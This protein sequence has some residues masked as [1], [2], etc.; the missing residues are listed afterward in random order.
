MFYKCTLNVMGVELD[1]T[2]MLVN[3]DDV[4]LSLKRSDYDGVIRSY[5]TKFEFAGE[6]RDALWNEYVSNYTG[7]SAEIVFSKR[8]N[9]WTYDEVFRCALDFSSLTDDGLK[10]SINA[11]DN[12]LAALIKSKKGTQYEYAVSE[13][14]EDSQLRYDR[15]MLTNTCKW[16]DGSTL[17]EDG[18]YSV[19]T[20]LE[21]IGFMAFPLFISGDPEI[22]VKDRCEVYDSGWDTGFVTEDKIATLQPF[23]KAI[24]PIDLVLSGKFKAYTTQW[25]TSGVVRRNHIQL[26]IVK[27]D[28]TLSVRRNI[29]IYNQDYAETWVNFYNESISLDAGDALLLVYKGSYA[30]AGNYEE[31][32]IKNSTGISVE[33]ISRPDPVMIDMIEPVT[34]LNRLLK[35]MNGGNEGYTGEIATAVDERLDMAR[36]IAAESARGLTNA[37]LYTSYTKFCNWMSA[38]FGFVPVVGD[39]TVKFVHRSSL[40]TDTKVKELESVTDYEYSVKPSLIYS[41]IRVGYDKKDYDSVNGKD[42]FNF[43]TEYTTGVTLTDNKLELISPYRADAYG[44]EFLVQKRGEDTTGDNSDNDVFF[45]G[46]EWDIA[47]GA[48][49]PLR[50][51]EKYSTIIGGMMTY[52]ARFGIEGVLTPDTMFNV[53][54]AAKFMIEANKGYIGVCCDK[55]EYASADGNSDYTI[56]DV[57]PKTDIEL[58]ERLFTVGELKVTTGDNVIPSMTEGYVTVTRNGQEFKGYIQ[59]VDFNLGRAESVG[60]TLIV[61]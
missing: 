2:D 14:K 41:Y 7:A 43:T 17:S 20:P 40:F 25:A 19:I 31:I 56:N 38:V 29:E 49:I 59:D 45:V 5:S 32:F 47:K 26:Y 53:M 36:I 60:Y 37:K 52:Y 51:T 44:L 4:E 21:G 27:E 58:G 3:W 50:K 22:A 8:N 34:V 54:Y 18:T 1:A 35:S 30:V 42:E 24:E 23:F 61:K 33:F 6:I 48:Y 39:T 12:S 11:V 46:V 28:G 55:L 15:L 16:I 57:S 10:L 9:S 13:I